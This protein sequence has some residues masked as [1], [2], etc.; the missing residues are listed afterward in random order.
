MM[1]ATLASDEPEPL[2][3][4]D[5]VGSY[6]VTRQISHGGMA[7]LYEGQDEN[8]IKVA[9]KILRICHRQNAEIVSRFADE[10]RAASLVRR[11]VKGLVDF[12][13]VLTL[14]NHAQCIVMEYLEGEP[15]SS[16]LER[17]GGHPSA[18][19]IRLFRQ[20]AS[21]LQAIHE[22]GIVH[23]DVTPK[24]VIII[25]DD[26]LPGGKRCKLIDFGIAKV[27]SRSTSQ[28]GTRIGTFLGNDI[29]APPEQ[30]T[31]A[32]TVDG[33]SDIYSLG[34]MLYQLCTGRLPFKGPD[35]STE[36]LYEKPKPIAESAPHI[37]SS[38]QDLINRMLQKKPIDRPDIAEIIQSLERGAVELE[39][40]QISKRAVNRKFYR[41]APVFVAIGLSVIVFVFLYVSV[42]S[43]SQSAATEGETRSANLMPNKS[44]DMSLLQVVESVDMQYID[45]KHTEL[46]HLKLTTFPPAFASVRLTDE[47]V[48]CRIT[49]T[50]PCEVDIPIQ[51]E[52]IS[53]IV[54]SERF[55][56]KEFTLNHRQ[57]SS[58]TIKLEYKRSFNPTLP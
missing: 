30:R 31:A 43:V 42:M 56:K 8:G 15:M 54:E 45:Q 28:Q 57:Q 27:P 33:K 4:G 40:L 18:H 17:Q 36:H 55:K 19:D 2:A 26:E 41:F 51:P 37:S 20:L 24:N 39:Q 7:V 32:H 6:C 29:Y 5:R 48:L 22:A 16:C 3:I 14:P 25:D 23:R 44:L 13:S 46:R 58:V 35:F 9:I 49:P 53:L 47:T 21:S 34:I 10:A 52:T 12:Y 38:L 50:R 11:G 1:D